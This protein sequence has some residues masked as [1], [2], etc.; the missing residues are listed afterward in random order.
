MCGGMILSSHNLYSKRP[1]IMN[2]DWLEKWNWFDE[3]MLWVVFVSAIVAAIM[4][5]WVWTI[6]QSV[7]FLVGL[8]IRRVL[9]KGIGFNNERDT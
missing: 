2:W 4:G 9:P 8:H 1:D 7:I 3:V 5:M 6:T